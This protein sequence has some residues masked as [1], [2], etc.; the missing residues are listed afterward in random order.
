M[1]TVSVAAALIFRTADDGTKQ[2]FATQRG[3]GDWRGWWE[4]PGGKIEAGESAPA[5]LRREIQEELAATISVGAPAGTIEY[6]YPDFHLS[7]QCFCC[8]LA[9]GTLRLLEHDAAAWLTAETLHSVKWLPADELLLD[10]VEK[11]LR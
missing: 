4:F 1:K 7:M 10:A 2:L 11:L 8:T 9:A 3:Y 5:A 6:D